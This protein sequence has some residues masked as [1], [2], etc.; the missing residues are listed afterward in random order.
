[1]TSPARSSSALLD[2]GG[3]AAD[4]GSGARSGVSG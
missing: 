4:A 2:Q 3:A 1:M